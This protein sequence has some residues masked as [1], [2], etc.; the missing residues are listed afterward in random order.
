MPK[1]FHMGPMEDRYCEFCGVTLEDID[2]YITV[3]EVDYEDIPYGT[4]VLTC[5]DCLDTY[6]TEAA[7]YEEM[8][9]LWQQFNESP[10]LASSASVAPRSSA[11]SAPEPHQTMTTP[12]AGRSRVSPPSP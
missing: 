4:V 5:A 9:E 8:H 7:E 6:E 11:S 3:L 12:G 10:P 1:P 2:A